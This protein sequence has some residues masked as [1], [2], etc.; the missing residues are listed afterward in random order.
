MALYH[1]SFTDRYGHTFQ[2]TDGDVNLTAFLA[3]TGVSQ[4]TTEDD[5][6]N[7]ITIT[8]EH[9]LTSLDSD[10]YTN[11]GSTGDSKVLV[12]WNKRI[13]HGDIDGSAGNS[14]VA[15]SGGHQ[16]YLI[17]CTVE[18]YSQGGTSPLRFSQ[19]NSI[20]ETST[21]DRTSQGEVAFINCRLINNANNNRQLGSGGNSV[22]ITCGELTHSTFFMGRNNADRTFLKPQRQS[23]LNNFSLDWSFSTDNSTAGFLY[24]ITE[25]GSNP[26]EGNDIILIN[27]GFRINPSNLFLRGY[28]VQAPSVHSQNNNAD[29]NP[30]LLSCSNNGTP[31][32]I[33]PNVDFRDQGAIQ[34]INQGADEVPK[35]IT[36]QGYEPVA[37]TTGLLDTGS[38]FVRYRFTTNVA[39]T[40][41]GDNV[42]ISEGASTSEQSYTTNSDG[43]AEVDG[44]WNW[45]NGDALTTGDEVEV[46]E[47]PVCISEKTAGATGNNVFT[48]DNTY[49]ET[50]LET[51]SLFGT[52]TE[53]R[54]FNGSSDATEVFNADG[55]VPFIEQSIVDTLDPHM[56]K[57]T[58]NLTNLSNNTGFDTDI[59][60][61][62]FYAC[63]KYG[64]YDGEIPF[65][66]HPSIDSNNDWDISSNTYQN[67][68]IETTAFAAGDTTLIAS[69]FA[70][71]GSNTFVVAGQAF[72]NGGTIRRVEVNRMDLQSTTLE[73]DVTAASFINIKLGNTD[74]SSVAKD[75]YVAGIMTV[76]TGDVDRDIHFD[77]C[78]LGDLEITS[79]GTGTVTVYGAVANDFTT[80]GIG[81]NIE[82]PLAAYTISL[83]DGAS[84]GL[85]SVY[86]GTSTTPLTLSTG[87]VLNNVAANSTIHVVYTEL[88][89]TDFYQK[90]AEGLSPTTQTIT[91]TNTNEAS[92][93]L[94]E[95]VATY[96]DSIA[97]VSSKLE[98]DVIEDLASSAQVNAALM[99]LVKAKETYNL[100]IKTAETAQLIFSKGDLSSASCARDYISFVSDNPQSIGFVEDRDLSIVSNSDL[101]PS[102]DV[103]I[104]GG[105]TVT[106]AVTI[107]SPSAFDPGITA[108][109]IQAAQEI[110]TS[111]VD[112]NT[113]PLK[114][115]IGWLVSNGDQSDVDVEGG[116]LI[117]IAPKVG[118]YDK[119]H[120]NVDQ[121]G[122]L[123]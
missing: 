44:T 36:S 93:A 55:S 35:V 51:Y 113:L 92:P 118:D 54:T 26:L 117:G 49:L 122:D 105:G 21:P 75:C 116:S 104:V 123:L 71:T 57:Y 29:T 121:Y 56:D 5:T 40:A 25:L 65:D 85:L 67:I 12:I 100:M 95:T 2:Q 94:T 114:N 8:G 110:I 79:T 32:M 47:I 106:I 64:I 52:H 84:G 72:K 13:I 15:V 16:L 18:F 41:N 74:E 73:A 9:N 24:T 88:G 33:S 99:S 1:S 46:F 87:N 103:S 119:S 20:G 61:Q 11:S 43:I 6:Y 39:Y 28:T 115:A 48:H 37:Y 59:T 19:T 90:I 30:T 69:T 68:K 14:A 108:S 22:S 50:S 58:R 10:T 34:F 3:L 109:Q 60:M 31:T 107:L 66:Q 83:P 81:D 76:V 82:F 86:N 97:I 70:T 4:D 7:N 62:E 101:T 120:E 89:K 96:F 77:N 23:K 111:N 38:P 42:T 80:D 27:N 112:G 98:I 78:T 45:R 63:A 17:N 91:V 102:E 53:E